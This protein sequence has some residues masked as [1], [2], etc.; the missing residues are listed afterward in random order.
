MIKKK[1]HKVGGKL[2][3][4]EFNRNVLTLMT[5]ATVAQAIPVAIA[6]ILTRIYSP[7]DFGVYALFLSVIT[8]FGVTTVCYTIIEYVFNG[9]VVGDSDV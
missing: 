4:S 7:E 9:D 3:K 2:L 1:I 8:I 5:G 6:P